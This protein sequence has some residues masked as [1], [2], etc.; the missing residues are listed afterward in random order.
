MTDPTMPLTASVIRRLA[1]FPPLGIARVGN[2]IGDD[3]YV[4][5]PE[6]VGGPYTLPQ[7]GEARFET[8]FRSADG[9]IKRQ[10]ARFRL[11]AELTNGDVREL[12]L[13]DGVEI[14]WMVRL[15]NLKAG[16]YDFLQAMDLPDGLAKPP[17]RR[18]ASITGAARAD[19][20][21]LPTARVISGA[22]IQGPAYWFDDGA[23]KG[24]SVYLGEL[25]T[26]AA[27]RLL[28]LGGRG[29][30]AS[31]P[32]KAPTTFA[33]NADWHDDVADGPVHASLVFSDGSIIE[34]EPGYVATTPPN[35]APGVQGLVTMDDAVRQT[36]MAEGW[37]PE[38]ATTSFT[39]DIWPIFERLTELQWVNHGHFML[40]GDSS[41][42]DARSPTVLARLRDTSVLGEA[43]RQTAFTLFRPLGADLHA[44]TGQLP[45]IFGDGFG[46]VDN[47]DAIAGL[48]VTATMYDHLARWAAGDFAD[49]WPAGGPTIPAFDTLTAAEQCLEL[50]RAPLH[51]CLGGPFHPGI[52]LTWTMRLVGVWARPY[53]LKILVGDAPARQDWGDTLAIATCLGAGGPYDG[54]A[55]GALT[56]FMGVPW[57]TDGASCNSDGDYHPSYYLSMPTFWG[58]RVPDQVL[59]HEDYERMAALDA[60]ESAQIDKHFA[61]RSDWL[62]DVRKTGYL[63][64]IATMVTEWHDLGMVLP[65]ANSPAHLPAGLRVEQGRADAYTAGDVRPSLTA[66]V[67]ALFDPTPVHRPVV[68]RLA[69]GAAQ[70][71]RPRRSYRQ[72]EI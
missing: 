16:W 25:R 29:T 61:Y 26:D 32:P 45:Q 60:P 63:K 14:R 34:A 7:G 70:P 50:E 19:L 24:T 22:D 71:E 37:L 53:R 41:P 38:P 20:D 67:E 18:N 31:I 65:V 33:N 39:A 13:A 42:L 3:D 66:A 64:R 12:T 68:K 17:P 4:F 46:E 36:F 48:C 51:D 43:W 9:A 6:V 1:V 28:A 56:R 15:A 2:A 55:A 30:S 47:G 62:R 8:D 40:N 23:F 59:A 44:D 52:E 35:F 57:Q 54:V 10:A 11:Y 72:G 69:M 27:G 21:I 49:D 58:P 5:G